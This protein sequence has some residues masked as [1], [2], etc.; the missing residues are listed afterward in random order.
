MSTEGIVSALDVLNDENATKISKKKAT[1][2]LEH[3]A[4]DVQELKSTGPSV[5]AKISS[6]SSLLYVYGR[7]KEFHTE[8]EDNNSTNYGCSPIQNRA[9]QPRQNPRRR[10]LR[11]LPTRK[12]PS[13]PEPEYGG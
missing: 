3:L 4:Q 13:V 7:M 10:R 12:D 9:N 2:S 6:D 8:P 5:I 11:N 1:C